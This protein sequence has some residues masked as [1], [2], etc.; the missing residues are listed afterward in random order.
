MSCTLTSARGTNPRCT[1]AVAG[2]WTEEP[3]RGFRAGPLSHEATPRSPNTYARRGS[4]CCTLTSARRAPTLAAHAVGGA[5]TEEPLRGF[6]AGPLSH[7]ATPRSP[8]TCAR[9]GSVCCTLTSARRAQ[10]LAAHAVA[11]AR[12]EEPLGGLESWHPSHEATPR[13]PNTC[14]RRGSVCCTLTSARRA[15]TLAAHAVAGARAEEPLGGLESWHS[16]HEATP[17][18]PNTCARR[19]SV[20]CTLTSARREP[21][22]AA[23]AVAGARAEEPLGGLESW[24]SSHEATPRCQTPLHG[25]AACAARSL[26][27]G[28]NQP[29]LHM[30]LPALGLKSPWAAWKAGP[31]RTKR[32]RA[33]C[34]AACMARCNNPQRTHLCRRSGSRAHGG[35]KSWPSSHEATPRSTKSL[36]SFKLRKARGR[37]LRQSRN[38][39]IGAAHSRVRVRRFARN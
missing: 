27:R 29:S 11:G 35:L 25:A 5:W 26:R 3:L 6:K 9:R 33:R 36:S 31:R 24:P 19:G 38:R 28:A 34:A 10:T 18:S 37:I 1:H 15:Q 20:C 8:N 22:L 7:E 2:A 30:P 14:A 21:T 12:A 16:Q 32:R 17:C 4:V 23:H 39:L 13:S